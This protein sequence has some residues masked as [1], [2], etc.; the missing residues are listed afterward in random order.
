MCS[1]LFIQAVI[2]SSYYAV[3]SGIVR[4]HMF[5]SFCHIARHLVMTSIVGTSSV[6]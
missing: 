5:V 2:V 4:Q 1:Q 6:C 3:D